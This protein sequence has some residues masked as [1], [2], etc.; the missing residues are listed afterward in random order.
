VST[1]LR[2]PE[3][4]FRLP[5]ATQILIWFVLI[6]AIKFDTLFAPPVWD[7]A[8]GVFPPA[9]FLYENNFNIVE[10]VKL[11][12]WWDG[13]PNVHS[14]SLW[15]WLIA[16]TMKI[17]Q[18]PT[19]TF[20]VLHSITFALT[21]LAIS[22][23]VRTLFLKQIHSSLAIASGL[24]LL[25]TPLV[26]VQI[27]Y[28]YTESPIMA[29]SIL[30]WVSWFHQ[31]EG[32]A[33][34]LALIAIGIKLT[35]LIIGICI[36]PLLLLR[37][38]DQ[39]SIKRLILLAI[40]P[41]G[42]FI[43]N[44]LYGWL[45]GVPQGNFWGETSAIFRDTYA[46]AM[47]APDVT[48]IIMVG[49]ISSIIY[50]IFVWRKTYVLNPIPTLLKYCTKDGSNFIVIS[51]PFLF[52]LGI[53]FSLY[54]N[55]LFIYRYAIPIIPFAIVSLALLSLAIRCQAVT[56]IF[57]AI[58]CTFAIYNY[59]GKIYN[60]TLAFSIVENAHAY[61]N[62]VAAQKGVIEQLSSLDDDTPIF[63]SRDIDYMTSHPMMGYLDKIKPNIIGIYKTEYEVIDIDDLP[64][65]IYIVYSVPGHG[66]E[67]IAALRHDLVEENK[68]GAERTYDHRFRN[69][70]MRLRRIYKQ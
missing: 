19:T 38:I 28:M 48:L 64:S 32:L 39:F 16:L 30:V 40:I 50:A 55:Q 35:G 6:L 31:R 45:N 56:L 25:L 10:L 47:H 69:H 65:E 27:G 23:L 1:F 5:V 24:L 33:V 20:F 3:L 43:I 41:A 4:Y 22:L 60:H 61:Q 49:I 52:C 15:T 36:I 7:T 44:S 18:D 11:P 2:L 66:G 57:V 54:N 63:V 8:M 14:L 51:Y 12:G 58:A 13:G 26:L 70:L 34:V 62:Y 17:T 21:A 37:L 53:V 9:I 67:R 42:Y 59:K 68:W 46:R 29:L